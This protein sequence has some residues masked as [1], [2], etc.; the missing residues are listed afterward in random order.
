MNTWFVASHPIGHLVESPT[1]EKHTKMPESNESSQSTEIE[2]EKTFFMKA[3]IFSGQADLEK[4]TYGVEE[5]KWLSK[6][7]VEKHVT[8]EYWSS[9]KNMLVEQ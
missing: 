2:S 5:F 9:V 1:E 8:S 3:R 6:E 4:N 7:E